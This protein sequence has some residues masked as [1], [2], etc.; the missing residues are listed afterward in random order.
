MGQDP[1]HCLPVACMP[2]TNTPSYCDTGTK[3]SWCIKIRPHMQPEQVW[4]G[5]RGRGSDQG[6]GGK[7]HV[8]PYL[9]LNC[10]RLRHSTHAQAMLSAQQGVYQRHSVGVAPVPCSRG[11][12][13]AQP[14]FV[15]LM[16]ALQVLHLHTNFFLPGSALHA[17]HADVRSRPQVNEPIWN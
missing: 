15:F 7:R 10:S 11:W 5:R 14:I 9:A 17:A 4:E 2:Q 1:R 8:C 12:W 16:Q 3:G 6:V 13:E